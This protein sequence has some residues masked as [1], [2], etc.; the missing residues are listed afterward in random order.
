VTTVSVNLAVT[1]ARS[2]SR[3]VLLMDSNKDRSGPAEMLNIAHGPG[4]TDVLAGKAMLGDCIVGTS[5]EG[6]S[7]LGRGQ[8]TGQMSIDYELA[9]LAALID[10]MK[11][12]FDLIVIDLPHAHELNECYAFAEVVDGVYLLF[13]A[14]RTD[15]RIAGR[16]KDR[17]EKCKAHLLGAIYNKHS[18]D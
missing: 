4:L 8:Q 18:T 5:V 11:T 15:R 6:M 3:R 1:A 16:V 7:F 13:E 2:G 14:G 10:K 12:E 17:L 9:D